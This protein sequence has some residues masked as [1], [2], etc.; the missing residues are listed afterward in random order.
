M[1]GICIR[2]TTVDE[3]LRDQEES[4]DLRESQTLKFDRRRISNHFLLMA[5]V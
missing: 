3:A 4:A 5:L 2:L 1:M